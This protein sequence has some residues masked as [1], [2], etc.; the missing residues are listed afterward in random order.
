MICT[1]SEQKE[2]AEGSSSAAVAPRL[3]LRS[4]KREPAE[5]SLLL[6]G[7]LAAMVLVALAAV[8]AQGA[9]D[10]G[11]ATAAI[12]LIPAGYAFSYAR[13]RERNV[14]L[15]VALAIG[16]L[17]ALGAFIR[18]VG[19]ASS[20]DDARR[21]LAALFV[22]VQVLHAFD[23]PRRR[24]LGF[25]AVSS[26]ILMAQAGALSLGTSYLGFLVPWSVLA[27]TWLFLSM[28]PRPDELASVRSSRRV[29]P[30]R[31]RRRPLAIGRSAAAAATSLVVAVAGVFVLLP[32]LPGTYVSL[33]PFS[34]DRRTAVPNF[35]G[36]VINPGLETGAGGVSEFS[37]LAYPGFGS[38]L[39]LRARGRL[40]DRIVMRVR[41]SQP[42]L[43]RGEVYDTFDGTTWTASDHHTESIGR[44]FEQSFDV[45]APPETTAPAGSSHVLATFY[46]NEVQPNVVF[47]PY[48]PKQ[49][50]FPASTVS[51]DRY[52]SIRSPILLE[53]GLV[54]SIVSDIPVTTPEQ[55]RTARPTWGSRVLE[56]YTQLPADLPPRDVALARRIT[57]GS[58]S[59]YDEV[60]AVQTWLQRHTVYDLDI[61]PDPPGVDAVDYFLFER[62]RGFCEHIASAMALLLRAVGVPTR[63]VTGFGP[64]D[65]NLFTGYYD[66]RESDA[67]AW[68]EVLYPGVGWVPYDPT[69]GVP[70]A[71]PGLS[72]RFLVPRFVRAVGRFLSEVLPEPVRSAAKAVGRAIVRVASVATRAWPVAIATLVL[73]ALALAWIRRRRSER[74]L[75][76][77]PTGAA[78]AFARIALAMRERGHPLRDPQTPAEYL[79]ELRR[80]LPAEAH[81]DAELVVRAFERQRF[82]GEA[83][84]ASELADALNAADRVR[85]LVGSGRS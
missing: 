51:V 65:R 72:G 31:G 3:R 21:P 9:L 15:K 44:A 48:V 75:G 2:P 7:V 69:F 20:F 22:W 53:P 12:L 67:H 28:R 78:V 62:R 41:S 83:L 17:V 77:P 33:P 47:A 52:T 45:P 82:S 59:I 71:D 54:Y 84:E 43:W 58:T 38:G 23:V 5:D 6:R 4:A 32:R 29:R 8:I 39:D 60:L 11:T 81:G 30:E 56:R 24:D 16:M 63:F 27:G 25:S 40:S 57:A 64:G 68:V 14:L 70:A 55:L 35:D 49:V 37:D 19:S 34:A 42:A 61:P 80:T 50:Y 13:R 1:R 46:M 10:A 74:R 76:P 26:L 73:V 18:A 36:S 85:A 79:A 66:V